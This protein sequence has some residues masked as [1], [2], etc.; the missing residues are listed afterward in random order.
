LYA[1][2]FGEHN[3]FPGPGFGY[4]SK[5]CAELNVYDLVQ[6]GDD[7][8]DAEQVLNRIEVEV[9]GAPRSG[10]GLIEVYSLM[11]WEENGK[12]VAQWSGPFSFCW[13]APLEIG[14]HQ[15]SFQ[16]RQTTGDVQEYLW[17]F[18]IR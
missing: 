15:V 3:L 18:E 12:T 7:F 10:D 14:T 6:K 2:E 8:T 17:Q 9:D 16:F 4:G 5:I 11:A 13:K 1:R